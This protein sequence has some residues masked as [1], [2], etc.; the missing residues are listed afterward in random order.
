M[1]TV[2]IISACPPARLSGAGGM[3]QSYALVVWLLTVLALTLTGC[4]SKTA[5]E[6]VSGKS[7]SSSID[8]PQWIDV[9]TAIPDV[10]AIRSDGRQVITQSPPLTHACELPS[11]K[12]LHTWPERIWAAYSSDGTTILTVSNSVA[13][14]LDSQTFRTRQTFPSPVPRGETFDRD[15]SARSVTTGLKSHS[16]IVHRHRTAIRQPSCVSST[17]PLVQS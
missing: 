12:R 16:P 2:V 10:A 6:R 4:K 17:V 13:S 15:S 8:S 14:V 1:K 3:L 7:T 11:G 9:A 5:P